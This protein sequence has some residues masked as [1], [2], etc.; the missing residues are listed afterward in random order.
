VEI[1][2]AG[3]RHKQLQWCPLERLAALDVLFGDYV[4]F[5]R[6]FR[7]CG[8]AGGH[9]CV[10]TRN[11]GCFRHPAVQLLS[12]SS[13]AALLRCDPFIEYQIDSYPIG[14]DGS[15]QSEFFVQLLHLLSVQLAQDRQR[16]IDRFGLAV[17]V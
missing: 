8:F 17:T 9:Q 16:R 4:K 14:L 10:T 11:G 5:S 15:C 1:V 3:V 13:R 2:R 7:Q 6:K 12:G